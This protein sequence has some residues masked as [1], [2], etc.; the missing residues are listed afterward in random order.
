MHEPNHSFRSGL[1]DVERRGAGRRSR[2]PWQGARAFSVA[3]AMMLTGGCG[4]AGAAVELGVS[5]ERFTLNGAPVFLLGI[6]YYGGLGASE[7]TLR[8]DL[9]EMQRYGFKWMRVWATWAAFDRDCSAVDGDGKARPEYLGRLQRL[10]GEC[11]RRGIVVDV[12]LSRGNGVTGPARLQTLAAHE[13]AVETLVSALRAH[14][15]WYLDLGNE[16]NVRDRRFVPFGELRQLR[17]LVKRLDGRRLVTAS[18]GGDISR[19][20]LREYLLTVRV[21]FVCPHRPRA[22]GSAGRTEGKSREYLAWMR[23]LGRVVPLHYQEP[24]RR[25][26]AGWEPTAVD[27]LTD[28]RA[29]RA[30]GAA[31]W[32]FHNGDMRGRAG[33]RPRRSFDLSEDRLFEQLDAE[34]RAVLAGLLQ[35]GTILR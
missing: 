30:G 16:R 14:R 25:G 17:D 9:D 24:F 4:P 27:F 11:D 13:Q 19:D 6:S 20:D 34:E 18:D 22:A 10:V 32:C 12:T 3:L 23:E 7:E 28:L 29:A 35:E 26:Y 5:G 15:N 31:G 8:R 1:F 21:D 33:G 2:V